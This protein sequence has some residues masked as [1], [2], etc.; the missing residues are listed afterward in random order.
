MPNEELIERL[1]Q[2]ALNLA[3]KNL[4]LWEQGYLQAYIDLR[5]ELERGGAQGYAKQLQE[6]SK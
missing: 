3:E 4:D 6:E 2:G 5:L 1:R